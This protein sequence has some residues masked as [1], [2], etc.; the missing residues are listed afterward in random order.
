ME[1]VL[2]LKLVMPAMGVA[3][4]ARQLQPHM[5]VLLHALEELMDAL[6]CEFPRVQD[7][8]LLKQLLLHVQVV[9]PVACLQ[10]GGVVEAG[11][12]YSA[13]GSQEDKEQQ[14]GPADGL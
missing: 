1:M 2:I 8:G 12:H 3:V 6:A 7:A 14:N 13:N 11:L 5:H 4:R 9:A 10:E